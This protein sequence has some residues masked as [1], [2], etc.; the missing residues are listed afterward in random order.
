MEAEREREPKAASKAL[1]PSRHMRHRMRIQ[2]LTFGHQV[3]MR[4]RKYSKR[5]FEHTR[6]TEAATA[7]AGWTQSES[8]ALPSGRWPIASIYQ[9]SAT[10]SPRSAQE[11]PRAPKSAQERPQRAPTKRPQASGRCEDYHCKRLMRRSRH[12]TYLIQLITVSTL[13]CS[14]RS[15]M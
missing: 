15:M 4:Q 1:P 10:P 12:A 5:A 2:L 3:H 11:R 8:D 6:R 13:N 7:W 14:P 9:S